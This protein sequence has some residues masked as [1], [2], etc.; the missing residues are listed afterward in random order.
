MAADEG[1][2]AAEAALRAFQVEVAETY[3]QAEETARR[4]LLAYL[5][6]FYEQDEAKRLQVLAGEITPEDWKAW[7]LS[8]IATGK[9][10]RQTLAQCAAAYT[11]ANELA[12][13]VFAG[14]LP[15]VYAENANYGAWQVETGA[16]VETSWSLMDAATV[17]AMLKDGAAQLPKPTVKAAKDRAWNRKQVAA[18]VTQGILLGEGIPAISRRVS[19]VTGANAATATRTARTA[20]TAAECAGRVSSY[21]RARALGMEFEQEWLATLDGRTRHSHRLL[22]G[23]RVEVG[24]TFSNGCRYPGDPE[25]PYGETMNCRCTLVAAFGD[26]GEAR[27]SSKLGGMSYAE[28]KASRPVRGP[29]SAGRAIK[30]FMQMPSTKAALEREGLSYTAAR[31]LLTAQLGETSVSGNRFRSL[32]KSDQQAVFQAAIAPVFEAERAGKTKRR[33]YSAVSASAKYAVDMERI[34]S[35]GYRATIA[36][37]VGREASSG[38]LACIKTMLKHRGGTNGEDMYAIDLATGCTVT[39]CVT[40]K[41]ASMVNPPAGFTRKVTYAIDGGVRI[42][43]LHNHPGSR[44]PSASDLL[45]LEAHGCDLGIIAAHDGSVYSFRKVSEGLACYNIRDDYEGVSSAFEGKGE[46]KLFNAIESYFGYRVEHL[47]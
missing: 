46:D 25:A 22:D 41:T 12:V 47:Q 10:Y 5:Q 2:G 32:T 3:R 23:E 36:R 16:G 40:S 28:W 21:E 18:Q 33:G 13:A 26:E 24:G 37:I 35:K 14:K 4:R 9:A 27:R 15:Q 11:E 29:Q 30:E 34:S 6:R 20:V 19:R 31:K 43:L 44:P 8:K 45:S 42:A 17:E 1:H 7:R 38:V 39:S